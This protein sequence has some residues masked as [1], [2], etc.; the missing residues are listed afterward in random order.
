MLRQTT[1]RRLREQKSKLRGLAAINRVRNGDFGS[2]SRAARAE[3]TTVA[4]IKKM[5]A[6]AL[7]QDHAGGRIRVKRSDPYWARVQILT[8]EGAVEVIARGS[9][10]RELSGRHRSIAAKVL[11]GK[12]P[13][14]ALE[15]FRDKRI[16]GQSLISNSDR[17]FEL[18]KGGELSQL[19]AVYVS[20]E[21]RG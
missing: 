1:R 18:L 21:T 12:L 7:V 5:L 4:T 16:G 3:G 17:L 11:D 2:L 10:Q 8:N 15:Q 9:R 19:D 13:P 20:P 14:D 6:A